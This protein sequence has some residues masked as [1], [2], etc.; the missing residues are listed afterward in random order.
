ML[1]EY[2]LLYLDNDIP[3]NRSFYCNNGDVK[4]RGLEVHV[5]DNSQAKDCT[6]LSLRMIIKVP[7]GD[8]FEATVENG[9]VTVLNAAG[10][11]YQVLF[12]NNMGKGRLIAEIQLSNAVP[13]IIVSR[14]FSLVSDGSL[15][16]DGV[17][18]ELPKA[19]ILWDVIKN[20]AQRQADFEEVLGSLDV[21]VAEKYAALETEYAPK[22]NLVKSQLAETSSLATA[23]AGGSPKGAYTTLSALQTA[24]P[25]GTVGAYVVT[26]N[27]HLYFWNGA[28]TD[29]G[30]VYQATGLAQK[31]ISALEINLA[32]TNI[33]PSISITPLKYVLKTDGVLTTHTLLSVTDYIDLREL[34]QIDINNTLL[35]SGTNYNY[36]DLYCYYDINKV[37]ISGGGG[38]PMGKIT[39][40][41][42]SFPANAVYIRVNISYANALSTQY[43]N[44]FKAK[45]KWLFL[46]DYVKEVA[47]PLTNLKPSNL[48]QGKINVFSG[49]PV[50][51]NKY[52][53]AT[54]AIAD[55]VSLQ[56]TDYIATD[57]VTQVELWNTFTGYA[58]NCKGAWYDT[59]KAFIS[60]MVSSSLGLVK[61]NKPSN[62]KYFR[63]N[64]AKSND[65]NG[66]YANEV[67][68]IFSAIPDWLNIPFAMS[69]KWRGKKAIFL[70]DSITEG[71]MAGITTPYPTALK[72]KLGLASIVNYG[73]GGTHL[74][75]TS[76]NSFCLRYTAMDNDA[77]LV[78]VMGGT[79][80]ALYPGNNDALGSMADIGQGNI[81]YH[82]GL[83]FLCKGL[84]NK[85]PKATIVFM[86]PL[87]YYDRN[88]VPVS[89]EA[90]TDLGMDAYAE[91]MQKVCY[92]NG[93]PVIDFRSISGLN[94]NFTTIR[95]S[96]FVDQWIH[97]N[98]SG[99]NLFVERIY[100]NFELY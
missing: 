14:K 9:L 82:G 36:S 77:D 42:A 3:I 34:E 29:S 57:G 81:S 80:D 85:Y 37:F 84:K 26:A 73:I 35:V 87:H 7:S 59:S 43:L 78:I 40:K 99:I 94:P 75:G 1:Q 70:G 60:S 100:K 44:I 31:S 66:N 74:A 55:H 69:S 83:D 67:I 53:D 52:I 89:G 16:S 41:K 58:F 65:P 92:R 15:T 18:S 11:I 39:I 2:Q 24:Y 47:T 28:W 13:E 95:S 46:D 30:V 86:T 23:M 93:I 51:I 45:P 72:D 19:G 56:Y 27:G 50:T 25:T 6:G 91:A 33:L 68:N 48:T 54:G 10:G 17:I 22:L 38:L 88:G 79:N 76:A 5:L 8:I 64:T 96:Y 90:N 20:E 12:P 63:V 4:S 49:L 97:P 71:A 21:A 98:Q 62:A 61:F 32:D